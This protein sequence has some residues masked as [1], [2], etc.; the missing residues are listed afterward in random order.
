MGGKTG[1]YSNI[2]IY[3]ENKRYYYLN[4]QKNKPLT[5][6]ELRSIGISNLDQTRRG[7][8]NIYGDIAAPYKRYCLKQPLLPSINSFKIEGMPNNNFKIFCGTHI[9]NPAVLYIKGFYVFLWD[10]ANG[11]LEYSKQQYPSDLIDLGNN[12]ITPD[13][14]KTLSLIPDLNNYPY[15]SINVIYVDLHFEEATAVDGTD[16]S[17]YFDSSLRDPRFGTETSNRLRA[18]FDI[19]VWEDY[20]NKE[21]NGTSRTTP[22]VSPYFDKNIFYAADFLSPDDSSSQPPTENHYR[23]PIAVMYKE[24]NEDDLSNAKIVDLLEL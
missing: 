10:D 21:I 19:R 11:Y 4:P 3:D 9:E 13:K 2:I 14:S 18:V 20:V 22:L 12:D 24:A 1:N 5:D 7:I 8:Q 23:V 17:I 6:D 16:P 15:D